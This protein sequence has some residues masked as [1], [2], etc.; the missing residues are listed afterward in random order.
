MFLFLPITTLFSSAK[1]IDD[2]IGKQIWC[3]IQNHCRVS[4][5]ELLGRKLA[6]ML[7]K[8]FGFVDC[9]SL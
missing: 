6:I 7:S 1:R 8:L 3:W 4:H 2:K 9:A 5:T